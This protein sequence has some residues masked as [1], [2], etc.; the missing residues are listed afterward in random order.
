MRNTKSRSQTRD[1]HDHGHDRAPETGM[2]ARASTRARAKARA[3]VKARARAKAETRARTGPR[4]EA[5][6]LTGIPRRATRH[7]NTSQDPK[8][9]RPLLRT[10]QRR[11]ERIRSE[12]VPSSGSHDIE[13]L[14]GLDDLDSR[15][16]TDG[17]RVDL[18][19]VPHCRP[20]G[21][22][23][24]CG[25][26]AESLDPETGDEEVEDGYGVG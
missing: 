26:D 6:P 22:L 5:E 16:A 10:R 3:R 7:H 23:E 24:H 14:G 12:L 21:L 11:N 15:P 1:G 8:H 9:T 17:L 19:E 2:V 13:E 25:F 20:S 4:A 18:G